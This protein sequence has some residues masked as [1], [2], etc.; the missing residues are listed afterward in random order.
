MG[1]NPKWASHRPRYSLNVN[2]GNDPAVLE[3]IANTLPKCVISVVPF[4]KHIAQK[5]TECRFS[6]CVSRHS[7]LVELRLFLSVGW[8]CPK[9]IQTRTKPDRADDLSI[10]LK[11]SHEPKLFHPNNRV[12]YRFARLDFPRCF[13]VNSRLFDHKKL[14]E[15]S[16]L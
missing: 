15:L 10:G 8:L 9:D 13:E 6:C 2:F 14:V 16:G 1:A 5:P 7:I 12:R 3:L 11:F 4:A